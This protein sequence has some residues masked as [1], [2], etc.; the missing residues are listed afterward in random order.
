MSHMMLVHF[1]GV[2]QDQFV[3]AVRVFGK[4]DFVHKWHDHRSHGDVDWD[5]DTVVLG[6]KGRTTPCK[7]SWQD[8][9]LY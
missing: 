5:S 4:P 9:E 3:N 6:D 1:V 2:T 7:W 8:H